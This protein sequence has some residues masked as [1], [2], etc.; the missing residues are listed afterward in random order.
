MVTVP[1]QIFCAPT[2]AKLIAARRSMP[3]VCAVL[4]SSEF[5]GMTR[6]PSCF[7]AGVECSW[8]ALLLMLVQ[9]CGSATLIPRHSQRANPRRLARRD[10]RAS[11][12]RAAG[13]LGL[14]DSGHWPSVLAR[15]DQ[16][17]EF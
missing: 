4:V 12:R 8:S 6:T 5:A 13:G 16:G 3:G 15:A 2:R 17:L 10:R 1:A 14:S 7:Q 11:A 9:S